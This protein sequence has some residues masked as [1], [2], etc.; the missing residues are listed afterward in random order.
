M[1]PAL[2]RKGNILFRTVITSF[3]LHTGGDNISFGRVALRIGNY[4]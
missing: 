3:C 2:S 4:E 1:P